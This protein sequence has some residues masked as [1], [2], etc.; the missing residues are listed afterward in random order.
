MQTWKL[1]CNDGTAKW[2]IGYSVQ[3]ES[4]KAD[5]GSTSRQSI[6]QNE[7]PYDGGHLQTEAVASLFLSFYQE[8]CKI[9]GFRTTKLFS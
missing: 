4:P 1:N 9:R 3:G 7:N 2:T 5:L 6:E 8:R